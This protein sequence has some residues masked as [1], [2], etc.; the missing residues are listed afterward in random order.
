MVYGESVYGESVYGETTGGTGDDIPATLRARATAARATFDR[1]EL[2]L[3]VDA[4]DV[5]DLRDLDVAV[6]SPRRITLSDG[7][8]E[9]V[10][11][12]D[13]A[14]V[15]LGVPSDLKPPWT[16]GTFVLDD[17]AE[18]P[19]TG[20]ASAYDV[21]I[22]LVRT[23]PRE[24][25]TLPSET[26]TADEWTLAFSDGTI[27]VASVEA[28]TTT[29]SDEVVEIRFECTPAQAEVVMECP[30]YQDS[31]AERT[32]PHGQ[33]F[34][35]DATGGRNEVAITRPSGANSAAHATAAPSGTYVIV[36]WTVEWLSPRRYGVSLRLRPPV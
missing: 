23:A 5:S 25:G 14:S 2:T 3:R 15:T 33:G 9:T 19:A 12:A 21:D 32:V 22:T 24:P 13:V 31:V 34:A 17:Y 6:E 26:A 11:P 7:S 28:D 29:A 30:T 36:D 1:V 35:R 10:A 27:A 4:Q 18:A 8:F 16:D 20:T